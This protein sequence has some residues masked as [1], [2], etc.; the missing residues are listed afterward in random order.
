[1]RVPRRGSRAR[2]GHGHGRGQ[3]MRLRNELLG[4]S[5][6][7]LIIVLAPRDAHAYVGPGAG[8][9]FATAA[10]ALIGSLLVVLIGLLGY[11]I[12]LIWRLARRRRRARPP[13]VRRAVV[14]G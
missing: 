2:Q 12:R 7:A 3:G 10:F 4:A 8:I 9:A 13:R 14:I 6:L 1:A 5:V 11:P